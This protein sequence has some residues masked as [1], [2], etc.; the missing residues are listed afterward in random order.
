MNPK[1]IPLWIRL[2][3]I[4]V[5][6]AQGLALIVSRMRMLEGVRHNIIPQ[7]LIGG[8][9]VLLLLGAYVLR[10]F[11]DGLPRARPLWGLVVLL[12]LTAGMTY[13]YAKRVRP[14][15]AL[16][17]DLASWSEPMFMIDAIKWHYGFPLYSSPEDS[18]SMPYTP[19]APALTYLLA[20]LLGQ[21]LSIPVYRLLQQF[22]LLLAA[23]L[24]VSAT[25]GLLHLI[26]PVKIP[27][28][29]RFL[30]SLL[31][32]LITFLFATNPQ[33]N[34]FNIFLHLDPMTVL[35]GVAGFWIMVR[36]AASGN[37]RWLW[38][39]SA[40]PAAAFFVKQYLVLL[41]AV[42]VVYLSL[43]AGASLR[44]VLAF[45][46][47]C[48]GFLGVTLAIA[49]LRWGPSFQYWT[50]DI[51]SGQVVFFG[52]I[53]DRLAEALPYLLP[54]LLGGLLL[55]HRAEGLRILGLFAGWLVM[56][57]GGAYSSGITFS[58]THLGPATVMGC[59]F[60]LAA[61]FAWWPAEVSEEPPAR[62]W[63]K[64]A[65]GVAGTALL[66]WALGFAS[67]KRQRLPEDVFRYAG[68]IEKEFHGVPTQQVLLDYGEWVYMKSGVLAKD[69]AP[70]LLTHSKPH[71]GILERIRRRDYK[72]ILIR[73]LRN[74]EYSFELG[75]DRGIEQ[76]MRRNYREVR[77]IPAVRGAEDWRY[78]WMLMSDMVVLEPIEQAPV[79]MALP[80]PRG[81]MDS[82]V[83]VGRNGGTP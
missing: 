34:A 14:Y 44:R 48:C 45:G 51:L 30:W 68:E 50:F 17:Y 25:W 1:S 36:H 32:F 26:R 54:G 83:I 66:F 80:N 64:L 4:A 27:R 73:L 67:A 58:P 74:G 39:M 3:A 31:F 60:F 76:E 13:L 12:C 43:E 7:I 37:V 78:H 2:L 21:P 49:F 20:R 69:R 61:L 19:G 77:R 46:M 55:L 23:A 72:K 65:S 56:C 40:F 38:A 35:M 70:I 15:L 71:F 57:L 8:C 63:L 5:L 59:A 53:H 52:S 29:S 9:C 10:N 81:G 42:Y 75:M 16:P 28:S 24:T 79:A 82:S 6:A 33:T 18:N 11:P 22:Y 47:A 41:A 62:E